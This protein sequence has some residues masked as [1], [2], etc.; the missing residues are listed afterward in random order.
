RLR[1]DLRGRVLA[2]PAAPRLRGARR[3][4]RAPRTRLALPDLPVLP[5]LQRGG[6]LALDL[7]PLGGPPAPSR[8]P[9]PPRAPLL[10]ALRPGGRPVRLDGG[11]LPA[12]RA[13]RHRP[14]A[15]RR[16]RVL[17]DRGGDG[18][19]LR[20]DPMR[21]RGGG[22]PRPGERLPCPAGPRRADADGPALRHG[23]R[24]PAALPSAGAAARRPVAA[25]RH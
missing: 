25:R 2:D 18:P 23:A 22:H 1:R 9:R 17:P 3:L 19:A 16:S 7:L 6:D 5:R 12:P 11:R 13:P 20:A 15:L 21:A 8:G 14:R 10:L 24:A 4:P